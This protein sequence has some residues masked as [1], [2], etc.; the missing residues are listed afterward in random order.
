MFEADLISFDE[1]T[2]RSDLASRWRN[3][4]LP[5]LRAGT[6]AATLASQI[7]QGVPEECQGALWWALIFPGGGADEGAARP[8]FDRACAAASALRETLEWDWD[9][10]ARRANPSACDDLTTILADVPRTFPEAGGARFDAEALRRTLDALAMSATTDGGGGC[11]Y[12]QGLS[13]AAAFLLGLR[14]AD[15]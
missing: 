5:S 7:L 2:D 6:P 9:G 1:E 14:L 12:V 8:G 13:H 3:E 10:R 11:G 15:W 4:L